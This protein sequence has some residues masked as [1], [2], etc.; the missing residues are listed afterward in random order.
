MQLPDNNMFHEIKTQKDIEAFLDQSN[1]LHDGYI[2]NVNYANNGIVIE[3]DTYHF[4]PE[5]TKL[6]LQILVTSI[7]DAIIEI[8]FEDLTEWQIKDSQDDMT[9]TSVIFDVHNRIIW[10]DDANTDIDKLQSGSYVIA[11]S[12][13]WRIV[14]QDSVNS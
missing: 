10:S 9:D 5:Q 3:G 6:T 14:N 13:K 12:M 4:D 7:C 8:V 2:V 1:S 11:G